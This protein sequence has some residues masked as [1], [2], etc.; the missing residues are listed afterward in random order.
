M[1]GMG[2]GAH[3]GRDAAGAASSR[4][5]KRRELGPGPDVGTEEEGGGREVPGRTDGGT[6]GIAGNEPSAE[7][8]D[9][10]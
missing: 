7:G 4:G 10:P 9:G 1:G 6:G 3:R 2:S 8:T 5:L